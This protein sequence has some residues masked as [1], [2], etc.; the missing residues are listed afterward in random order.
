MSN[1]DFDIDDDSGLA[2]SIARLQ[3]EA[4]A[5][6]DMPNLPNE[7][8]NRLQSLQ[9]Q[10]T[11]LYDIVAGDAAASFEAVEETI[12]ARPWM[13]VAIAFGLGWFVSSILRPRRY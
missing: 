10:I 11:D 9:D 8:K 4:E 13:S 6:G 12:I 3:D 2:E 5:L 7:L 1:T